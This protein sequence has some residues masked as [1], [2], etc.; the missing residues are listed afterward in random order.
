M[1]YTIH[2]TCPKDHLCKEAALLN[3]TPPPLK[4]EKSACFQNNSPVSI[5]HRSYGITFFGC[6]E[7]HLD[8]FSPPPIPLKILRYRVFHF[9]SSL[10]LIGLLGNFWLKTVFVLEWPILKCLHTIKECQV[11][12]AKTYLNM[13]CNGKLGCAL[14]NITSNVS[15]MKYWASWSFPDKNPPSRKEIISNFQWGD[16]CIGLWWILFDPKRNA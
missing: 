9:Y 2:Q 8:R 4:E 14:R 6:L 15:V 1:V 5:I 16:Y 11:A 13:P 3:M 10:I 7:W 12:Y